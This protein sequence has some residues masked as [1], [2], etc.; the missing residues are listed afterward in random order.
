MYHCNHCRV[1]STGSLRGVWKY[2]QADNFSIDDLDFGD[3]DGDTDFTD[4]SSLGTPLPD[5]EMSFF[6]PLH[7]V[8]GEGGVMLSGDQCSNSWLLS[9]LSACVELDKEGPSSSVTST[10]SN[11]DDTN[12]HLDKKLP[13]LKSD[14]GEEI[15]QARGSEK[16]DLTDNSCNIEM[17]VQGQTNNITGDGRGLPDDLT[18]NFSETSSAWD[19]FDPLNKSRSSSKTEVGKGDLPF[20]LVEKDRSGSGSGPGKAEVGKGDLPFGIMSSPSHQAKESVDSG[21][22]LQ[23]AAAEG[24]TAVS[25]ESAELEYN[26]AEGK[27]A[28]DVSKTSTPKS[29]PL[30][31]WSS[32]PKESPGRSKLRNTVDSTKSSPAKSSPRRQLTNVDLGERGLF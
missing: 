18:S 26:A 23:P 8:P 22:D 24:K 10:G 21:C 1:E 28:F 14:F 11:S 16:E 20:S 25:S 27:V 5:E 29:S 19:E 12:E 7:P 32:T 31:F 9:A 3:D 4:E 30:R 6:D 15:E 17:P 2:R 13:T